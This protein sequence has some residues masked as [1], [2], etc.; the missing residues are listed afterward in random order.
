MMAWMWRVAT[1]GGGCLLVLTL[2]LGMAQLTKADTWIAFI[3]RNQGTVYRVH[4]DGSDLEKTAELG[5]SWQLSG[6]TWSPDGLWLTFAARS[7][8]GSGIFRMWADGSHLESI[9]DRPDFWPSSP[10]W[11]PDGEKLAFRARSPDGHDI[12]R[13][14]PD[15]SQLKRL[16]ENLSW[17]GN[18]TWSPDGEW[19][20]FESVRDDG[21]L[22]VQVYRMR[23]DGGDVQL[24]TDEIE[25]GDSE[26]PV[27]S[28]DGQWI[29]FEVRHGDNIEIYRMRADGSEV[30]RLTYH[31]EFDDM[32]PQWSPDGQW[33]VYTSSD[34]G[35]NSFVY[36]IRPDGTHLRRLTGE[37]FRG[38][39][40][41]WS[42]DGQWLA[43]LGDVFGPDGYSAIFRMRPDGNNV[44]TVAIGTDH[45]NSDPVWSPIIDLPWQSWRLA[46]AGLVMLVASVWRVGKRRA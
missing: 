12:Y 21:I 7:D 20:A 13:A 38:L 25:H 30:K 33:L 27:W 17:D 2:V 35:F 24:L 16:T 18:P 6:L 5:A 29:A 45:R 46:L 42:P 14:R 10:V 3:N 22:G 39:R 43:F 19:L 9:I 37:Q 34:N 1:V 15:G 8:A 28:S 23:P 44:Q 4:P 11:S 41:A 31:R 36:R 40:P 32:D 26:H